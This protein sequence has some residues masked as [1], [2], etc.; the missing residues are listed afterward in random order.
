MG[1]FALTQ[2][3][4]L[5]GR[6][7]GILTDEQSGGKTVLLNSVM[8]WQDQYNS[9]IT[10]HA[11]EQG[12][13]IT[14]NVF[15]PAVSIRF[16]AILTD[17]FNL[18]TGGSIAS[19][20]GIVSRFNQLKKWRREKERLFFVYDGEM[21]SDL[22]IKNMSREKSNG[23]GRGYRFSFDLQQIRIATATIGGSRGDTELVDFP[24]NE[25]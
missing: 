21:F 20:R 10:K 1:L 8:T 14:D 2:L 24:V 15:I 6:A 13:P 5:N 25:G 17:S 16:T 19:T 4:R 18:L 7:R 3:S 9:E 22:L 11:V 12:A 23:V